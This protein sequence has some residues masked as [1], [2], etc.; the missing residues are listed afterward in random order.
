MSYQAVIRNSSNNLVISSPVGIQV[1]IL[2]GSVSG[3]EVFKET[4]NPNPQT[5]ANGLVTIEIG[6]GIA[7]SGS[8][9]SI[10]WANGPY[11]IKT[12]ID[13]L[14]GTNYTITGIS[15]LLSVPYA[16]H[17]KTAEHISGGITESDPVFTNHITYGITSSNITDWN[18]AYNWG[19]HAG[20]YSLTSHSH[21]YL[22]LTGGQMSNVNL[23]TNLNADLLDGQDGSFYAPS[24]IYPATGL[25]EGFIPYKTSSGLANSPIYITGVDNLLISTYKGAN[26][27]GNNIWIG[28]GGQNSIGDNSNWYM[29]TS[30]VTLGFMSGT[31]ITTGY[32]NVAIGTLSMEN[33]QTGF[34]NTAV[35]DGSMRN[36]L[37]GVHNVAVGGDALYWNTTGSENNAFGVD[38]LQRNTLGQYNT[39]IGNS[40]LVFNTEG[41]QN[42]ALGGNSLFSNLTGNFNTAVGVGALYNTLN[43]YNIGIGGEA[44]RSLTNGNENIF[45]GYR[46][47][48]NTLQKIDANNS[49]A[50]GSYAYTNS[51]NQVVIGNSLIEKTWLRGSVGIN[52]DNPI[53]KLDIRGNGISDG[54]AFAINNSNGIN[55]F[56]VTDNGSVNASSYKLS[57]ISTFL[58]WIRS[59]F[60]G[61]AGQIPI[62]QGNN[63]SPVWRNLVDAGIAPASIYPASGLSTGF[64]PYK[65]SNVL[66]NSSI[67]TNGIN[68][69]INT[70][71]PSALLDIKGTDVGITQAL[72]IRNSA[73]TST[74]S[75][76]NN[77]IINLAGSQRMAT[78]G[79]FIELRNNATGNLTLESDGAFNMLLNPV[80]GNVL[81]GTTTN[82]VSNKLQV[83]GAVNATSYK[84][85]GL[86]T[87]LD[88]IRTGHAGIAGQIPISQGNSNTPVWKSLADAGI[89]PTSIYPATGL[90]TGYIPYKTST[91]LANSPININGLYVGINN[92]NPSALLDVKGSDMGITPALI[93]RNSSGTNTFSIGNNGIINLGGSQ[94]MATKGA[95]IE[96]RDNVTGA[97]TLQSDG[98]YNLLLNPTVSG[99]VGIGTTSPSQKLTVNGNISAN[100]I[101]TAT[102]GSS[103]NW[104]TAYSW[105]NHSGLYRPINY[106]PDWSEITSNPFSFNSASNNQ[107]LKYNSTTLKWENWT[108]NYLTSYAESDPNFEAWNKSSGIIITA[109][110]VSD[111]QTSVSNNSKVVENSA[112]NSYPSADAAKLADIE[113]GAEVNVNA[114]WNA[115]NGD[116]Q[117]LNKPEISFGTNPGDMQ[118]WDGTNW[119]MIAAGQ[120]GQFL[121]F[122]ASNKPEWTTIIPIITTVGVSDITGNSATCRGNVISNSGESMLERGFCWNT[123]PNPTISNNKTN[124]GIGEGVF[125]NII[126]GLTNSTTYY[127]RA[128]VTY[129]SYT[130]Y[131]NELSFISGQ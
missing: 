67:F 55:T 96:L 1:S 8:F 54:L 63:N 57:G 33:N 78:Q 99:K 5:N 22:P 52:T 19:N 101:I 62:S 115:V 38:A 83:N 106:V 37:S 97:L 117:I 85:S 4:Y 73:G 25:N 76:G 125:T 71:S 122:T 116:A 41:S 120:P 64:I 70:S 107:L 39:S 84:L 113:A 86:S 110:Q 79:A 48:F 44:G 93:I 42:T 126:E 95:Y 9:S 13:I 56:S 49:I 82:D 108:P 14:G 112:K 27:S 24:S 11:F 105:G 58:D 23:V 127:I 74:F 75:I 65:T 109:S 15:E 91:V 88:W 45:I 124:N 46:S 51:N 36:N 72:V 53:A 18:S 121:Q 16:L 7:L 90:T 17:S 10:N 98:A 81:I 131:G 50:I 104:N 92:S 30:N 40:S 114:D 123:S 89:A 118:Y 68:V 59:G 3:T 103:T 129:S 12:E 47:G 130:A 20:L 35:G 77:G 34:Y 60:A 31:S 119:V 100:G 28:G 2:Q 29:G 43:N 94:R 6:S 128:Y 87:F 26:S 80:D 32:K 69:G 21:P 102:G 61:V 111:F 66:A